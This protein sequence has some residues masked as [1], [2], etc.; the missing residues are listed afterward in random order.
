MR[1]IF[2]LTFLV[3][4]P[5]KA[6][7][8]S[9]ALCPTNKIAP[10][11]RIINLNSPSSR[12]F[13]AFY[14]LLT[15]NSPQSDNPQD[16]LQ[17]QPQED[18]P[19]DCGEIE[20]YDE[21]DLSSVSQQTRIRQDRAE[22][23]FV[24]GGL[25]HKPPHNQPPPQEIHR[26]PTTSQRPH[27]RPP[28]PV[29]RPP[30]PQNPSY[31]YPPMRPPYWSGGVFSQNQYQPPINENPSDVYKPVYES[32]HYDDVQQTYRPGVVGG[33]L[34]HVVGVT[35]AQPTFAPSADQNQRFP[36]F[37]N[38]HKYTTPATTRPTRRPRPRKLNNDQSVVGSFIDLFFK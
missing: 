10:H 14:D 2:L 23:R 9:P 19:D 35:Q 6:V 1:N 36:Y 18:Q 11:R 3:A 12:T 21:N 16:T 29:T 28:R 27:T 38:S 30:R 15:P 13:G 20:D 26:P 8:V 24:F 31:Y 33:T 37:D 4:V 34:N 25:F 32:A 7:T 22:N 5:I 17:E